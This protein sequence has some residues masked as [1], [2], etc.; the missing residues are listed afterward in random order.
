MGFVSASAPGAGIQWE[1]LNGK[2][3]VIEPLG[4]ETGIKTVHGESDA[5]RANVYALTGP[6]T[7][8][9]YKDTLI[10]PKVLIG[11]TKG[12]IGDMICGRLGQGEKKPGQSAPWI[13][14]EAT[15][16]DL[17]KAQHWDNARSKSTFA[18]TA[19]A[20]DAKPPF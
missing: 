16:D 9:D 19:P 3:L 18:T 13:I 10:F 7:S 20:A 4:V 5:V 11:Q 12:H 14:L 8:D 2:L 17:D 15:A 1:E 6:E